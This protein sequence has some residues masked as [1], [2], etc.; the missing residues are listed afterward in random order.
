MAR[1]AVRDTEILGHFVPEGTMITVSAWASHLL[2]MIWAAAD[3][4]DPSRYDEP[5][6][7][8]KQ[9]RLAHMAFGGGAHKCIGMSFGR[10]EVKALVHTILLHHRLELPEPGY[11][12]AWDMTSLPSPEDGLPL[13]LR[14]LERP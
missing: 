13:V 12:V 7:E 11:E 14:P 4:F 1:R 2:P 8:D 5:R 3:E 10:A 6:R 9:H